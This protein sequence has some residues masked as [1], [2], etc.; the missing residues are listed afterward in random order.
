MDGGPIG[1][2]R[3][4]S[5]PT[6]A[7]SSIPSRLPT[8]PSGCTYASP[9]ISPAAACWPSTRRSVVVVAGGGGLCCS[10]A[11]DHDLIG[12]DP[13]GD[14]ALAGPV[15]SVDRVVLHRRIEPEAV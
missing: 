2:T 10:G 6:P 14:L 13:N 1:A 7:Q 15:L 5:K 8:R 3:W 11:P 4:R 9:R 12:L